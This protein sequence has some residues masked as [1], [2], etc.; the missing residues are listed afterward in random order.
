[1]GI[2]CSKSKHEHDPLGTLAARISPFGR[3]SRRISQQLTTRRNFVVE[4]TLLA[5][6]LDTLVKTLHLQSP[7]ALCY[8]P[9]DL[10]Q[11]L[12]ERLVQTGKL[13]DASVLRLQGQAFYHLCLDSYPHP[14]RDFWVRFLITESI[15]VLDLSRT[16]VGNERE[17]EI[18]FFFNFCIFRK[19]GGGTILA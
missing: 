10:A 4:G 9:V 15:E 13:N 14:I 1:M 19:V 7:A 11:L 6:S 8:L 18:K 17:C 5:A 16:Q 2:L 12:L 3:F